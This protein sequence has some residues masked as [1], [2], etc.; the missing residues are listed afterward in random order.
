MKHAVANALSPSIP[1]FLPSSLPPSLPS[2]SVLQVE[3]WLSRRILGEE[4]ID[5]EVKDAFDYMFEIGAIQERTPEG[6]KKAEGAG[7]H[8][9]ENATPHVRER[10]KR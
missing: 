2:L 3:R 8:G 10:Q 4:V 1:P 9:Q 7:T 5:F 6:G